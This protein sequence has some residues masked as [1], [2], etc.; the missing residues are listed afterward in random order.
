MLRGEFLGGSVAALVGG[1]VAPNQG[2]LQQV[3]LGVN[4]PL[5]GPL[6]NY[7]NEIVRGIQACVD[8]TNRFT[9]SPT[10]FWGV[11]T[12]DDQ[13]SPTVATSNVFV[14]ASDP[15]VIGMIGN[16]TAETTLAALPQYANASFAIVVPSVTADVITDRGFRNVFRLP[17]KDSTEGQLYARSVLGKG[18]NVVALATAG[19]YGASIANGLIAQARADKR[20]G[21]LVDVNPTADPANI[22]AVVLKRKPSHVFLAGKPERFGPIAKALRKQGYT[23]EFGASDSFFSASVVDP[24]GEVMN[25]ALVVTSQPPLERIPTIISLLRDFEAQ[26]GSIT[27]FSAFG[28]AAAQ[29]LMQA[30]GRS[31]A[32]DRFALLSQL[33]QGG[34]YN[35][36]VGQYAFNFS[37]DASLPN[38]Y[39][40]RLTPKGFDYVKAAVPSGFIL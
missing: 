1:A 27:A 24:Y 32:R 39:L 28:Y 26:V 7:G 15:S 9:P 37:G 11:R 33:Q 18:S 16:L 22:A 30:F 35:L 29:L 23:G 14:A 10:H 3:N 6:A 12:F 36:I 31:N 38:V 4:V 8:E 21:S 20:D 40:Y 25:G 13:N 2:F 34:T 17:T 5:T 19:D